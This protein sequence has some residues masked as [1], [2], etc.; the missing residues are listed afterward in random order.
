MSQ[1]DLA[2]SLDK[3]A[4]AISELERG[5]IHQISALDLYKLAQLLHK[6]IEYF[7]GEDF[8]GQDI[9][10]LVVVIRGMVPEDRAQVLET[11]K[12]MAQ[13]QKIAD[14]IKATDS[15]PELVVLAG[16]LYDALK[17]YLEAVARISASGKEAQAKLTEIMETETPNLTQPT[18][19]G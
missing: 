7:Y 16:E 19:E 9:Q 8:A 15:K 10:D 2:K 12:A 4:A 11:I 18:H 1:Q 3:S 5:K 14:R 13:M 17:P 6:P